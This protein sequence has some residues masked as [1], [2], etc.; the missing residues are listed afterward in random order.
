M[1]AALPDLI[2]EMQSRG[3]N[4]RGRTPERWI[5][6]EGPLNTS[7][8]TFPCSFT[9]DPHFFSLPVVKL[10][11]LPASLRPVTPHLGASGWLC[12]LAAST[13]VLDIFD[14]I[15]QTLRC[16][17]EAERVLGC[18]LR[19]EMVED[20]AEEF[21][22]HWYSKFCIFD[23]QK[24]ALGKIPAFCVISDKG[25][26]TPVLTDDQERTSHRINTLSFYPKREA[27]LAYLVGTVAQPRPSQNVWPPQTVADILQWQRE[28]DKRC[29]R[30]ILQRI[31]EAY[32]KKHIDVVIL[33]KS[34]NLNYGFQVHFE[35]S[36]LG[37]D[38]F[39]CAR[40][41]E[42]L[43]SFRVTRLT[44]AR[45][46]EHYIAQRNIPTLK[47][48]AGLKIALVGCGTIGGYLADQ[49]AK[50]GA[51]M[52]GGKLTLVD[53]ELLMPQNVGRH[54]LGLPYS[55]KNKAWGVSMMLQIDA[56][57]IEVR[58]LEVDVRNAHLGDIDL[59]IDATGEE[60]LGHWLAANYVSSTPIL[61]VW[62][63]GPGT[64]VRALL[65]KPGDGAC[66]RCLST[67]S[68][69]GQ[70]PTVQGEVPHVM[71]GHG[72]EGLYVPFPATVSIQA[73]ALGAEM[74]LAWANGKTNPSLRTK[75]T[76][77]GFTLATADCDPP[78]IEACPACTS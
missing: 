66:Y 62:I 49:L 68:R 31:D 13:V 69:A 24:Q 67:Y 77:S 50:A 35:Q 47:T 7:E 3:F 63:E 74:V 71:A 21:L 41:T 9:V 72:C 42:R 15:G 76:D 56:P 14:P 59:L 51:G 57:G 65:K 16:L 20:L 28:L 64:A 38:K 36:I 60:A 58:T 45:I 12:Y 26:R 55:L 70:F 1:V 23:V 2:L 48:L 22:V 39:K 33:I 43:Y 34:P 29:A 75:I 8:G 40:G 19:G 25:E 4:Y 54:R 18:V 61:S 32:R 53:F 73:A 46:D 10:K 17:A 44:M 27:I 6:F 11:K 78:R 30:K 37:D 5:Q 52:G